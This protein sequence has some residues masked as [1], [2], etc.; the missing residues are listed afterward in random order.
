MASDR[1]RAA[2]GEQGEAAEMDMSPMID[3]V[4]LLLLFF[5]VVSNPKTIKIDEK[6]KPPVA[7]NG[8]AAETIH[9][10]IVINIHEDGSFYAEDKKQTFENRDLLA[11]YLEEEKEKI[12][13]L[14]YVPELHIRA[15]KGAEF[16]FC[17][18]A[19]KAGATAGIDRLA[20]GAFN[21][22]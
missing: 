22:E 21:K 11:E 8:S 20:Y 1:L 15:D 12:K 4:F 17:Q 10:K 7:S 2:S 6:V 14:G 16:K 18:R 13:A 19:I 5:L 9:G 3:M